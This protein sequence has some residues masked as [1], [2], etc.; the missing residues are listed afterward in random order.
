MVIIEWDADE[1]VEAATDLALK[2]QAIVAVI[3]EKV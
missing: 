2:V 1:C 3:K